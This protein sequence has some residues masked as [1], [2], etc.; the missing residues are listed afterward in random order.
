MGNGHWGG[1]KFYTIL[2]NCSNIKGIC[3]VESLLVI[4]TF[5]KYGE[6]I[7]YTLLRIQKRKKHHVIKVVF[8]LSAKMKKTI[9]DIINPL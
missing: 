4:N 2:I 8:C 5:W 6:K 7:P 9:K 1:R 3:E